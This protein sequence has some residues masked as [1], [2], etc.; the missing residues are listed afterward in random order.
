MR[1]LFVLRLLLRSGFLFDIEKGPLYPRTMAVR[2]LA[3]LVQFVFI[4]GKITLTA[5]CRRNNQ[6]IIGMLKALDKMPDIILRIFLRY[7]QMP[8][9]TNQVHGT[10]FK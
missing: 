6:T 3:G 4:K 10:I 1:Y 2:A 9:D 8:G 7:L 5:V